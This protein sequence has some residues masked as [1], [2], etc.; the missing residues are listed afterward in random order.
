MN[1]GGNNCFVS[2]LLNSFSSLII[3]DCGNETVLRDLKIAV[4]IHDKR[5][6]V[7]HFKE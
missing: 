2:Y 3:K 7:T 5:E 6:K 1:D 4:L